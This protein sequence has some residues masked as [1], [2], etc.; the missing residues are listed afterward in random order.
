M[1]VHK[2]P[3]AINQIVALMA[4]IALLAIAPLALHAQAQT[5]QYFPETGHTVRDEFLDFFQTGLC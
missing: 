1:K 5:V 4:G 2:P 3:L